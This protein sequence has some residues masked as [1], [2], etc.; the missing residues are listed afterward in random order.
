MQ[1]FALPVTYSTIH[2]LGYYPP[3]VNHLSTVSLNVFSTIR[4]TE[5]KRYIEHKQYR[6]WLRY[7]DIWLIKLLPMHINNP[8]VDSSRVESEP[9][10]DYYMMMALPLPLG[11]YAI[12]PHRQ[13]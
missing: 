12:R 9:C 7:K 10:P 2:P 5:Y 13:P 1:M 6:H 4:D 8:R 11:L 3:L